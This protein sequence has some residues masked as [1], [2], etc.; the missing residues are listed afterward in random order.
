MQIC[1]IILVS[2]VILLDRSCAGFIGS[3]TY[4][5]HDFMSFPQSKRRGNSLV[6]YSSNQKPFSTIVGY[7]SEEEEYE[8]SH[9]LAAAGFQYVSSL[10]RNEHGENENFP[11]YSYKYIKANGMLKLVGNNQNSSG[12]NDPPKWIPVQKGE[13]VSRKDSICFAA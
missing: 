5:D 13:E 4:Q 10:D 1:C 7:F 6:L 8:L 3:A 11:V 9:I 12:E 2:C